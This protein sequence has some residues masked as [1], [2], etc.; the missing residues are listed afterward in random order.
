MN[1]EISAELL[2]HSW[3]LDESIPCGC[4]VVVGMPFQAWK[5]EI[6]APLSS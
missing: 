5:D 1:E 6:S 4:A 3:A 2:C